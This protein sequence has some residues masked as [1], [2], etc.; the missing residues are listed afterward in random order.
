MN[1]FNPKCPSFLYA[2]FLT[3]LTI[4]LLGCTHSVDLKPVESF[5]LRPLFPTDANQSVRFDASIIASPLVDVSQGKTQIIVPASNGVIAALDGETGAEIWRLNAPAPDRQRVELIATPVII[6]DKLIISYQCINEKG[7]RSSHRLAVIDLLNKKWDDR[8]PVLT[9]TAEKTEVNSR[10][11][12]KFNPSTAFSHAALQ[13]INRAGTHLGYVYAGFG[14]AQDTQ[15]FHGWLFEIDMDAWQASQHNPHNNAISSVLLTTPEAQCQL[16]KSDSGTQEMVCGGGIWA[17][18]G[19]L[20]NQTATD[21]ELIVPT[22]NGQIDLARKDYANALMRVKPGLDFDPDCD[23]SLCKNFDPL[24]PDPEC[25]ASC[26]NLFMP[27]LGSGD[28]PL[29]PAS[30]ECDDKD[31]WECL[32]YMDYDFGGSTPIKTDLNDAY[33]LIVQ[34]AKDGS[35]YLMDARHLGTQ[36]DRIQVVDICGTKTDP[37]RLAWAGMIVTKPVQTV[38]DDE[39][40]VVIPTFM[41]DKSHKAGL[42]AL[43]IVLENGKPKFKRFWQ[44]PKSDSPDALTMFRSHPTFPVL[45]TLGDTAEPVVWLVDIN[46]H[47]TVYGVRVRDGVMVAK[48][49]L[50]GAGR[51]LSTPV[52]H[53]NKLYVASILPKT[54][55]ALIEAFA[56]ELAH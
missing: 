39:P 21:N 25:L 26:K 22:G 56:I 19:I 27:R 52:I 36:Y 44:F 38:V 47:G 7:E 55:K 23:N 31:Y 8:F 16:K 3:L 28:A 10:V 15:P 37:C 5:K 4:S 35:V 29:K 24:K 17:P 13:H 43:K 1:I 9:L 40:I 41:P 12:V 46:T 48:Q 45:T 6:G 30:G 14:S 34:A 2:A 32:A 54:G 50:Q 33:S 18:A 51:Q 11:Q 49:T 20:I 53:H 42:I